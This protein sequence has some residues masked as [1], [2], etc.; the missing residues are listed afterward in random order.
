[1]IVTQAPPQSTTLDPTSARDVMRLGW[2]VAE[3]RGRCRLGDDPRLK[4]SPAFDRT[5]RALPLA[6]ERSAA[7]QRIEAEAVLGALAKAQHVDFDAQNAQLEGG[8]GLGRDPLPKDHAS[9]SEYLTDRAVA[10]ASARKAGD[11]VASASVWAA[12]TELFYRWDAR[13]W[14]GAA[15]RDA[16]GPHRSRP[17]GDTWC[18]V[19]PGMSP[20]RGALRTPGPASR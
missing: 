3:V 6:G 1:M 16:R 5:G 8:L 20:R 11:A 17:V 14:G 12:I 18:F 15:G 9:A 7:E 2:M 4:V 10:L 19:R 13:S